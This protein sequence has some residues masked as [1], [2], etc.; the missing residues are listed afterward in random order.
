MEHPDS[1]KYTIDDRTIDLSEPVTTDTL[2]G[3]VVKQVIF[4]LQQLFDHLT[5]MGNM[6]EAPVHVLAIKTVATKHAHELRQRLR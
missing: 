2:L 1:G 6:I 4:F 5:I 3:Y